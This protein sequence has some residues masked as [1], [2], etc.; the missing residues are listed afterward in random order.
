MAGT[1]A[2]ATDRE[3]AASAVLDVRD[4][5]I[6]FPVRKGA[7]VAIYGVSFTIPRCRGSCA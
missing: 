3:E 4:L 1:T 7:L 2:I 6:E 5:R